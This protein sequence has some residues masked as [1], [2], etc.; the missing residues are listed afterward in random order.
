KGGTYAWSLGSIT[1]ATTL[2]VYF[3]VTN[4]QSEPLPQNKR[5]FLQVTFQ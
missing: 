5:R 2:A 3:E 4:N 1:P